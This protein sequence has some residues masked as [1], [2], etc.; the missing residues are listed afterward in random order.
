VHLQVIDLDGSVL[1]Q[2][3][4]IETY[5]PAVIPMPEWGP[6]IRL[7]CGFGRFHQFEQALGASG[8][9]EPGPIIRL[10]GSGDFHHVSLALICRLRLP[11]NLLVLDNHPDWMRA[12]PLLHCGTWLNHA[13]RLPSIRRVFHVGGDMD[14]DNRYRWL[15]PWDLLK[16]GKIVVFPAR[17]QFRRTKWCSIP[18]APL[19]RPGTAGIDEDHIAMLLRPFRAELADAPLYISVDKD[20]LRE[21]DALGNWDCGHLSLK[22]L[23][24]V[25]H[26]F[27]RAAYGN[28]AGVDL[29]GDWSPIKTAGI[30]RRI[31]RRI[32]HHR[33]SVD[34]AEA[35]HRNERANME[36]VETVM[37]AARSCS[38][39]GELAVWG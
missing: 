7:A 19:R 20:V 23:Q 15:A 4:L 35:T 28:V 8:G 9:D 6:R 5:R 25:I 30:L 17:R 1:L 14:F 13:A 10:Y 11:V 22:D 34:A 32:E 21:R 3:A 16:S 38:R 29:L 36:I 24:T 27:I 26:T 31:L 12:V 33:P 18:H 2:K 37:A 39:A